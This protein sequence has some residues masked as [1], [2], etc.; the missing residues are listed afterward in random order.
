MAE[1]KTM[2]NEERI[3]REIEIAKIKTTD[4]L[5]ACLE[6]DILNTKHSGITIREIFELYRYALIGQYEEDDCS[7]LAS[8]IIVSPLKVELWKRYEKDLFRAEFYLNRIGV[9]TR[10]G[11]AQDAFRPMTQICDDIARVYGVKLDSNRNN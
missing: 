3:E 1:E 2:S 4:D 10:Q 6:E 8:D 7:E 5:L 11:E 9:E